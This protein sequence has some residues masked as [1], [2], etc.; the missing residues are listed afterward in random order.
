LLSCSGRL[1]DAGVVWEEGKF[2]SL[3]L[4]LLSQAPGRHTFSHLVLVGTHISLLH[5]L[6]SPG[7]VST[8]ADLLKAENTFDCSSQTVDV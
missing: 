3:P 1:R 6:A 4:L 8:I 5:D 7:S 2:G